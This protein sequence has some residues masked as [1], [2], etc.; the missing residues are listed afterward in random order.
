[1]DCQVEFEKPVIKI[2]TN[3]CIDIIDNSIVFDSTKDYD[4]EVLKYCHS[5]HPE[6]TLENLLVCEQE[7]ENIAQVEQT[8]NPNLLIN[9]LEKIQQ[10]VDDE[11]S[12]RKPDIE[13]KKINDF[14]QKPVSVKESNVVYKIEDVSHKVEISDDLNDFT[15]PIVSPFKDEKI[16]KIKMENDDVEIC[17]YLG[18]DDLTEE[19]DMKIHVDTSEVEK[20]KVYLLQSK[21]ILINFIFKIQM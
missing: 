14:E 20:G 17:E 18:K 13:F 8:N 21:F 11:K 16:V 5:S 7:T 12:E 6:E 10:I 4:K 3:E 1:M 15:K 19:S 2:E 9:Q